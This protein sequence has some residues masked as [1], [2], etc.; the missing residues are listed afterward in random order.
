MLVI[1]IVVTLI[2][3]TDVDSVMAETRRAREWYLDELNIPQAHRISTGRGVTVAVIDSG[4]DATHPDLKGH[5]LRGTDFNSAF[6]SRYGWKDEDG[7]GTSMAG[8]IA[9]Q[10]GGPSHAYGVAPGSKILPIRVPAKPTQAIVANAVRW[11]ADHGADIVNISMSLGYGRNDQEVS[12][13]RYALEHDV[14]VV[15]AAGNLGQNGRRMHDPASIPGVVAVTGTGRTGHFWPGSMRGQR[16]T[17]AAPAVDITSID[18]RD[19]FPNGYSKGTGTSAAAAIVSGIAALVRA[20]F[21]RLDA[22]NIIYRL[23]YT[24]VDEGLTGR[25][26]RYGYGLVSPVCALT[27]E[28]PK[29]SENPLGMPKVTPESSWWSPDSHSMPERE[30]NSLMVILLGSAVLLICCSI[31]VWRWCRKTS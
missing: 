28:V 21:P 3:V 30:S 26:T 2:M 31:A 13:I 18:S 8:I 5:V 9:A 12:A 11:A 17:I 24:A 16:A 22:S 25:D 23:I 7:H 27:A 14:V 15:A 4:L 6:P 20:K 19:V 10:G 29:V 1:S